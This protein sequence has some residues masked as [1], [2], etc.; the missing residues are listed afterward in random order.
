MEKQSRKRHGLSRSWQI[1][2]YMFLAVM[3][4]FSASLLGTQADIAIVALVC[5]VPLGL[6]MASILFIFSVV[7]SPEGIEWDIFSFRKF[8]PWSAVDQLDINPF[9]FVNL[10]FQDKTELVSGI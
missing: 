3:I 8:V 10:R 7:T 4:L 9:G 6:L 1:M 5:I 2:S